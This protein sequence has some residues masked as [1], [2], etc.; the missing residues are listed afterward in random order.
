MQSAAAALKYMRSSDIHDVLDI[1]STVIVYGGQRACLCAPALSAGL[2]EESLQLS[3][4]K[5][6]RR[7]H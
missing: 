5:C 3:T 4:D 7:W 1:P 6:R 2:L